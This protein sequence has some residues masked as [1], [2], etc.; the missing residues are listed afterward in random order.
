VRPHRLER[1]RRTNTAAGAELVAVVG[2]RLGVAWYISE[3]E[4]DRSA[5]A[6][7]SRQQQEVIE[8]LSCRFLEAAANSSVCARTHYCTVPAVR[9]RSRAERAVASAGD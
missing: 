1:R 7:C 6:V 3:Y 5:R 8:G 9:R 2:R 4:L